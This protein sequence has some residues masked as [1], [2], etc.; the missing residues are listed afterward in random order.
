M[1]EGRRGGGNT[2]KHKCMY[3]DKNIRSFMVV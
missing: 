2:C 3:K 1:P